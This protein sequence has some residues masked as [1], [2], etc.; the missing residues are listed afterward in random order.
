MYYLPFLLGEVVSNRRIVSG[1]PRLEVRFLGDEHT[2]RIK[3]K[4]LHAWELGRLKHV[5]V[6]KTDYFIL[7]H[8]Q[9]QFQRKF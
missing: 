4:L 8:T 1:I 9:S 5:G 2:Y 3:Q 6:R 7:S